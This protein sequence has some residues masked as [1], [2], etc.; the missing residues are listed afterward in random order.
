MLFRH[1]VDFFLYFP[2]TVSKT[3]APSAGERDDMI[4]IV[5]VISI[6]MYGIIATI[7]KERKKPFTS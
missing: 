3:A 1:T 4:L 7:K 5:K 2:S 6:K